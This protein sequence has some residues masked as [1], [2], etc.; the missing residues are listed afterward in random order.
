[1][2]F[3]V[4]TFKLDY[5]CQV[6]WIDKNKLTKFI[7]NCQD[8]ENGGISDRPDNVV[9]VYHTYFGVAGNNNTVYSLF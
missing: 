3:F 5:D 2:L 6:H 1:M 7:L 9:D 4:G 8:C